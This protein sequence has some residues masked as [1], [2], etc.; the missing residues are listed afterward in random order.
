MSEQENRE[1]GCY[2]VEIVIGPDFYHVQIV[3]PHFEPKN[4]VKERV[5]SLLKEK[6]N[7]KSHVE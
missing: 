1:K 7:P 2:G 5:E 4:D 3:V 6:Q